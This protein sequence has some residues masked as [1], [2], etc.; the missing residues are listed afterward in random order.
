MEINMENAPSQKRSHRSIA[1]AV[2]LAA[3]ALAG[4]A[5]GS[6]QES[7]KSEVSLVPKGNAT[8][9]WPQADK[10]KYAACMRSNGVPSFPD[11]DTSG[12]FT[13]D[14]KDTNTPQFKKAEEACK[15]HQPPNI[16]ST[17]STKT[18]GS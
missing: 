15:Q 12:A 6:S 9:D 18:D 16:P 11:L 4:A 14:G 2:A 1:L 7:G 3:V 13:L 10:L 5:C 17:T 8:A